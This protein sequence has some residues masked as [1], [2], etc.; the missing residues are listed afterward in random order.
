MTSPDINGEGTDIRALTLRTGAILRSLRDSLQQLGL[1][2]TIAEVAGSIPEARDRLGYVVNMTREAAEGVLTSVELT[3]PLQYGLA[4]DAEKLTSRWNAWEENPQGVKASLKLAT[5][6]QDWL[7]TIPSIAGSTRHQ[8]HAIMMAQ[9]FQDLTGQI[10]QRMVSVLN[11]V[12]GQLI[13]VLRDNTPDHISH[14]SSSQTKDKAASQ[15]DVDD[16]LASLG[17]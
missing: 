1:D 9:G 12:E 8:L 10:V 17:L 3:Q 14:L 16:L 7:A 6:T 4:D 2:K 11:D 5:D 15:D 13:K